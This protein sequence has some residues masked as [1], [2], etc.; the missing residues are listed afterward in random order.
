MPEMS[1]WEKRF[2]NRRGARAYRRTLD[3][4]QQA[5]QL[6]LTS[7]SQVLEL[8]AGNGMLSMLVLDR[9]HPAHIYLTDYDPEQLVVARENLTA[10]LGTVPDSITVE[11]GDA[12]HLTYGDRAFDLVMAHHV[13]HHLGSV[14][15][16]LRGLDEIARVLRPGGRLFYVE[17]F[18]KR[19][20]REHL[21]ERGFT[22]VFRERAWRIFNTADV[23]VAV[24]PDS[25]PATG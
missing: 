2:V 12:A 1:S 8:G 5:G 21:T 22:I 24:S 25:R 15:E 19:P 17:M 14:P 10:Q 6:P 11:R 13:L 7:S 20:I 3:R 23:I 4:I 9:F 18:H 16:I